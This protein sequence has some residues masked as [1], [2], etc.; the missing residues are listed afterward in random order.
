L[1]KKKN[2]NW[3]WSPFTRVFGEKKIITIK[4]PYW[5]EIINIKNNNFYHQKVVNDFL[6][7]HHF[8]KTLSLFFPTQQWKY[9]ENEFSYQNW[10]NKK[11]WG[12]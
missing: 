11:I 9:K 5:M 12:L 10:N 8:Y 1:S 2:L 4:L 7:C 3:T 6:F